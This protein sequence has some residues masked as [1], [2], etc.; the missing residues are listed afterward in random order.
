MKGQMA[1]REASVGTNRPQFSAR[2]SY[3]NATSFQ[4]W[5]L[6][7]GGIIETYLQD[8][9]LFLASEKSC[10]QLVVCDKGLRKNLCL[11]NM[12]VHKVE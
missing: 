7:H 8:E 2:Q 6:S 3:K 11:I 4:W 12:N 1:A 9:S 10:I 5:T